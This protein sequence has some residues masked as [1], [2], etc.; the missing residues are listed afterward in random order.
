[1]S[2]NRSGPNL[3]VA[4]NSQLRNLQYA[5]LSVPFGKCLMCQMPICQ[6]SLTKIFK[7]IYFKILSARMYPFRLGVVLDAD[8]VCTAAIV[9]QC[10]NKL[11]ATTEPPGILGKSC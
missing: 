9:G 8:E 7:I 3:K 5:L 6:I 1:M 11:S 10:E 2:E 4:R